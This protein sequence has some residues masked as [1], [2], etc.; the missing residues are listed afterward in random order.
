M[1][2]FILCYVAL[3]AFKVILGYVVVNYVWWHLSSS[4]A[5][6][7]NYYD[8]LY[9]HNSTL[10]KLLVVFAEYTVDDCIEWS[11]TQKKVSCY[12]KLA[13]L[14]MKKNYQRIL[15]H[16][17]WNS[18]LYFCLFSLEVSGAG[19]FVYLLAHLVQ[20][21]VIWSK[22]RLK[23]LLSAIIAPVVTSVHFY[24]VSFFC[25]GDDPALAMYLESG[26]LQPQNSPL[27]ANYGNASLSEHDRSSGSFCRS[28]LRGPSCH[29]IKMPPDPRRHYD[30]MLG[31]KSRGQASS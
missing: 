31:L 28:G 24:N 18:S 26:C 5:Y 29:S 13:L 10:V 20:F 8:N 12:N 7:T 15:R 23:L 3:H 2:K 19:P 27:G 4:F 9:W 11:F 22:L 1:K 30:L 6:S 16:E 21:F 14:G 17:P 25:Q